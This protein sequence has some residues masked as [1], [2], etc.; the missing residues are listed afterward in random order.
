MSIYKLSESRQ[1]YLKAV[2]NLRKLQKTL[3][4]KHSSKV[5]KGFCKMCLRQDKKLNEITINLPHYNKLPKNFKGEYIHCF[6]VS[7]N[8]WN[9][10]NLKT[11]CTQTFNR[12]GDYKSPFQINP[13]TGKYSLTL[14]GQR[15]L[16]RMKERKLK[17]LQN[18]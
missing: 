10:T 8:K 6:N 3:R 12:V 13:L 7:N 16:K 15:K 14:E 17:Q 18:E 11:L 1:E 5:Y 9:G 4:E 2:E